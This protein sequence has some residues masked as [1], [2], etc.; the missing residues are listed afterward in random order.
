[1]KYIYL[2]LLLFIVALGK[3]QSGTNVIFD[4]TNLNSYIDFGTASELTNISNLPSSDKLSITLWVKWGTK[5]DAG[6]YANIFTLNSVANGD[7]GVFWVQH[8]SDKSAF[9]F[10]ITTTTSRFCHSTTNPNEGE[11]YHLGL[12]YDGASMKMYVNGSLEVSVAKTGNLSGFPTD[13]KMYMGRWSN[14]SARRF[15][16]RIDEVSIW[17]IAL[18]ATQIS[19]ISSNPESVTGTSYNAIGLLGYWNFEGGNAN[20]LTASANNGTFGSGATLPV[21]LLNFEAN[22]LDDNVYLNWAT[23]S[24]LNND[25]FVVE[26]STDLSNGQANWKEIDRIAG[27]GTNNTIIKYSSIDFGVNGN[28][29]VLYYRLK[30][31]DYDGKFTYSD[32]K[33]VSKYDDSKIQSYPNPSNGFFKIQ[34][35]S[36]DPDEI[37]EVYNVL[38][39][40][41]YN[42]TIKANNEI[43]IDISDQPDGIYLVKYRNNFIKVIKE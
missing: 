15:D 16:G 23:A 35:L 30:Q 31:V 19:N 1:M 41:V 13:A 22:L 34:G 10:K 32:V 29:V 3:S 11:W 18:T 27:A 24:E 26:R 37:L 43:D 12:I 33:A 25:Y 17:N 39:Q 9:E 6:A 2:F 40:I 28:N 21:E 20:D 5:A 7:A 14:A 8:N 42:T 4:G 36:G 38:G